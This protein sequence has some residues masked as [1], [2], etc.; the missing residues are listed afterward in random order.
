M[1]AMLEMAR[2]E[3][4]AV[5][6][7]W[8]SGSTWGDDLEPELKKV[9]DFNSLQDLTTMREIVNSVSDQVSIPVEDILGDRR[10]KVVVKARQY[11]MWKARQQGYS[12]PQIGMF[13]D[14]DHTT[15]KHAVK[16][17]EGIIN[18]S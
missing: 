12:L 11:C 2:K 18:G 10:F 13:F 16:K 14:R 4:A 15:I 3:N 9:L 6:K 1:N 5:K 7:V 8:D 17:I